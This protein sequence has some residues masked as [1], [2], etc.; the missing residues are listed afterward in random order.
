MVSGL[1]PPTNRIVNRSFRKV[2]AQRQEGR[3]SCEE[4]ADV[5][6]IILQL[7]NQ[8]E[9][10][11]MNAPVVKEELMQVSFVRLFP[12]L[13]VSCGSL[14]C[15]FHFLF[16]MFPCSPH[17]LPTLSLLFYLHFA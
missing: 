16:S 4:V 2:A 10:L 14:T 11:D 5:E 6:A 17:F 3:F 1:T 12:S 9:G 7:L 15:T 8:K 13:A